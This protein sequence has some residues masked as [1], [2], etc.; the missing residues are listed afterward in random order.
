[1]W[2]GTGESVQSSLQQPPSRCRRCRGRGSG[3]K[4][5]RK[6]G[7]VG[8]GQGMRTGV[9]P[10][11]CRID[12]RRQQAVRPDKWGRLTLTRASCARLG[13]VPITLEVRRKAM[14]SLRYR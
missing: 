4:G 8:G 13:S 3:R 11:E 9:T 7:S 1:M 2:S 6:P 10:G 14:G 5:G 12:I